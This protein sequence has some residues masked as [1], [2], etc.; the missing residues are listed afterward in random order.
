MITQDNLHS[1]LDLLTEEQLNQIAETDK[2]YCHVEVSCTNTMAW[3]DITLVDDYTKLT[4]DNGECI[5]T[6]LG[7]QELIEQY[8]IVE[9]NAREAILMQHL[10]ESIK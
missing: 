5:L 1:V 9:D 8:G 10:A 6:V 7:L 2:E 3:V 4:T